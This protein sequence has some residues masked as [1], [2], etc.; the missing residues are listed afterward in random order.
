TAAQTAAGNVRQG[1]ECPPACRAAAAFSAE[2]HGSGK[3]NPLGIAPLG[4]LSPGP[5]W[6][7]KEGV[8]PPFFRSDPLFSKTCRPAG[9]EAVCFVGSD[10]D[11]QFHRGTVSHDA[12]F[13]LGP[14]LPC[15][16]R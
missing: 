16:P 3:I 2:K 9:N 6:L 5:Y 12:R 1:K 14:A 10:R 4:F 13:L 8:R 7:R 15:S 11:R